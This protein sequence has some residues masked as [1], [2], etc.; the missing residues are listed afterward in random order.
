[1]P[2]GY[3][4]DGVSQSITSLQQQGQL[5]DQ[6]R[7]G[8]DSK[9]QTVISGEWIGL[10]SS[11]FG[12]EGQKLVQ[13]IQNFESTLSDLITK[14]QTAQQEADQTISNIHNLLGKYGG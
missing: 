4:S 11:A 3:D 1:M 14:L 5:V 6:V 7:A 8:I 12:D 9:V 13:H 10:G 2:Y